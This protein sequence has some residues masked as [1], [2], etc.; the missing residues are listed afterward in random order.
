MVSAEFA[1]RQ[2]ESLPLVGVLDGFFDPK[3]DELNFKC[4]KVCVCCVCACVGVCACLRAC[5]GVCVA[6]FES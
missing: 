3:N 1:R 4:L 5:V 2:R 6:F